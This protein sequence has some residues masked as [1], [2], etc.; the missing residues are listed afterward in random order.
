MGIF[1]ALEEVERE[2]LGIYAIWCSFE[3]NTTIEIERD[4]RIKLNKL[5]QLDSGKS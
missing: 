4:D 1:E 2:V 5:R 3:R